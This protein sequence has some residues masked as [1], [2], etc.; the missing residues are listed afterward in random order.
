MSIDHEV[1]PAPEDG[2]VAYY[3]KHQRASKRLMESLGLSAYDYTEDHVF[4]ATVEPA[5]EGDLPSTTGIPLND[6]LSV[7]ASVGSWYSSMLQAKGSGR[8]PPKSQ[9]TM[10]WLDKIFPFNVNNFMKHFT[11]AEHNSLA[12][13][14]VHMLL[15]PVVD[16]GGMSVNLAVYED[17]N[18]FQEYVSIGFLSKVAAL[19]V[20][21]GVYLLPWHQ[22]IHGKAGAAA[23][24]NSHF[25]KN[26]SDSGLLN[27]LSR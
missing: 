13:H 21:C 23:A 24:Y 9:Q 11:E 15:G 2:P 17:A 3:M 27:F 4:E 14:P 26:S 6:F 5:A 19:A 25:A 12:K 1:T 16:E 20:R 10:E 8:L 22:L 18:S 7:G